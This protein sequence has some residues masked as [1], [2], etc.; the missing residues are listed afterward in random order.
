MRSARTLARSVASAVVRIVSPG[1]NPVESKPND[2]TEPEKATVLP[3]A[4][5]QVVGP[6]SVTAAQFANVVSSVTFTVPPEKRKERLT[7][8]RFPAG[9]APLSVPARFSVP[10][11]WL[12]VIAP[13]DAAPFPR[14]MPLTMFIVPPLLSWMP[15]AQA[16]FG[17]PQ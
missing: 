11:F 15:D 10:A 1:P 13:P 5:F 9:G 12:T 16:L 3:L 17:R 7:A 14:L 6:A 4:T 2:V 8:V